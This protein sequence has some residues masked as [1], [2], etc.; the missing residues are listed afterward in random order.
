M[1]QRQTGSKQR[2]NRRCREIGM[3]ETSQESGVLDCRHRWPVVVIRFPRTLLQPM[4]GGGGGGCCAG[5]QGTGEQRMAEA[6]KRQAAAMETARWRVG[7]SIVWRRNGEWVTAPARVSEL[8]NG[9]CGISLMWA[10]AMGRGI[11]GHNAGYNEQNQTIHQSPPT[12]PH[13]SFNQ[14]NNNHKTN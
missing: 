1:Y 13:R 8:T 9:W 11:M 14:T 2:A 12:E 7:S 4:Q 3:T 6:D 10:S 5:H